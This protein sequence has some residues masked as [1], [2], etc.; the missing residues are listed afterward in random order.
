MGYTRYWNRTDK[1]ITNECITEIKELLK[2]CADKGISIKG[3]TGV[4][5]PILAGNYIAFNGDATLP[6][7]HSHEAFEISSRTGFNC[8]KTE[9]KPY[10]Y[11]VRKAI[12]ICEKYGLINDVSDDGVNEEIISDE[13]FDKY[14]RWECTQRFRDEER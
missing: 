5:M 11:A 1:N 3:T 4:E 7:N 2:E 10:D 8:C 13:D 14:K 9:R 6:H 12:A